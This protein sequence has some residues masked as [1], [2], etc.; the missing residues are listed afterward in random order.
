MPSSWVVLSLLL[1]RLSDVFGGKV[2]ITS[3]ER[4][5][6]SARQ[7]VLDVYLQLIVS[8]ISLLGDAR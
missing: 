2:R 5:V 4:V 6:L 1:L 8:M 7:G 3:D